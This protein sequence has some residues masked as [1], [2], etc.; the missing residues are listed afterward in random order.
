MIHSLVSIV[1]PM[2]KGAAYIGETI[3]SVQQQTYPYWEMIIVDDCSPDGGAGIAEV[4]KYADKDNRIILVESPINRGSSGARNIALHKTH[5]K[6]IAFLDADDI[7]LPNLL[8]SQLEFMK[9]KNA[10]IAFASYHRVNESGVHVLKPFIVPEKVSYKDILKSNPIPCLTTIYDREV[11]GEQYFKEELKSL[12]D[13]YAFWLEALKKVDYAYGNPEI[14]A[15]YR[16]V[17]TSVTRNR[18]KLIKPQ[19]LIYYKVERLGLIKSVYY[20]INW[21]IRSIIKYS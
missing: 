21:A 5:G 15:A 9:T 6:Y 4:K 14:L 16:L 20:L 10:A 7:W 13:D 12:R 2:Y 11:V 18:R 3:H 8:E 19:F 17:S 1:T